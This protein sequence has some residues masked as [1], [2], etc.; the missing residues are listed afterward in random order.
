MKGQG[1]LVASF[2]GGFPG[3]SDSRESACSPGNPGFDP[4][5]GKIPWSRKWQFLPGILAW[6]MLWT[7]EPGRLQSMGSQRVRHD[8]RTNNI[9]ILWG[10]LKCQGFIK[11][12]RWACSHQ[13]GG[14]C[15][16]YTWNWLPGL[17]IVTW[18]Q[19]PALWLSERENSS[20]LH[21]CWTD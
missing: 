17:E 8:C 11:L 1:L 6:R 5:V 20:A 10:H 13:R 19:I 3:G 18:S 2:S 14:S 12:T 15:E 21:R 16:M 9:F 7:E 4:W